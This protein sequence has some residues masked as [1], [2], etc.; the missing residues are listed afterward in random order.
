[1]IVPPF[2]LPT[3]PEAAAQDDLAVVLDRDR[4]GVRRS[5]L[6]GTSD[7]PVG[8]RARA[9]LAAAAEA[10]VDAPARGIADKVEPSPGGDD[11]TVGLD[12]EGLGEHTCQNL[13]AGPEPAGR[14]MLLGDAA[15]TGHYCANR[16]CNDYRD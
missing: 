5:I 9:H 12:R 2:I 8:S 6:A 11:P 7:F 16:Y 15:A 10:Q 3:A 14:R 4:V 13:A 1:K